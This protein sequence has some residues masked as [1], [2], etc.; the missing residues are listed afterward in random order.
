MDYSPALGELAKNQCEQAAGLAAARK[1][2]MPMPSYE[3]RARTK[4]LYLKVREFQPAHFA[5]LA[6]VSTSVTCNR[7]VP[8]ASPGAHRKECQFR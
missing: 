3:R 1:G 6:L 8:A 2:E 5:A 7:L 4:H